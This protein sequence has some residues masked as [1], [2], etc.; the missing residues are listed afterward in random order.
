MYYSTFDI[1]S[2]TD[3]SLPE[4]ICIICWESENTIDFHS[5]NYNRTCK[6]N[7]YLHKHCI[8]VWTLQHNSCP[9]CRSNMY[10]IS[11]IF[12]NQRDFF[13]FKKNIILLVMKLIYISCL[14][15]F[16]ISIIRIH[17]NILTCQSHLVKEII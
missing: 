7:G 11:Y 9:I 1:Y 12:I 17:L 10:L 8:D 3:Q 16:F 15:F 6:C 5:M 2:E 14:F 4:N 13:S